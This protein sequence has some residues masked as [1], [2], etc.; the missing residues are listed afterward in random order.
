MTIPP[1]APFTSGRIRDSLTEGVS[2]FLAELQRMRAVVDAARG[3]TDRTLFYLLDEMLHGTNTAERRIAARTVIEHLLEQRTIGVV[4]T[5]DLSLAE[6]TPIAQK[7]ARAHFTEHVTR[8]EAGLHMD[9]D[10]LL[11]PGLATSS[12]ALTLLEIVGLARGTGDSG[13]ARGIPGPP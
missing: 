7:A 9:F 4:T 1:L 8:D 5:H 3:M 13:S 10:Y 12:N 6:E 2:L 11:R